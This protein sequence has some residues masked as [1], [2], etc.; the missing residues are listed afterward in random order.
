MVLLRIHEHTTGVL[1]LLS[2]G[3]L[4]GA[5]LCLGVEF[6]LLLLLLLLLRILLLLG[7]LLLLLVEEHHII[8][9]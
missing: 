2:L 5:V 9:D 3:L 7:K 8:T 6:L 4:L 1:D